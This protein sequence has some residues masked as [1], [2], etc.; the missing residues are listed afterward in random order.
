MSWN[1]VDVTHTD[2]AP[3]DARDAAELLRRLRL[4]IVSG[5]LTTDQR[6]LL[7]GEANDPSYTC[8]RM[9]DQ[10]QFLIERLL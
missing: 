2:V 7:V 5:N 9:A 6:R 4:L 1:H 8:L 3:E 10:I